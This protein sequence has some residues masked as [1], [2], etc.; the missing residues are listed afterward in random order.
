MHAGEFAVEV[1]LVRR[2]ISSQFPEWAS[3]PLERVASGGT[4]NA[5]F[6]LGA[7]LCVRLPR[8]VSAV[9]QVEKELEWL[10]RLAPALPLEIPQPL[11]QGVPEE[12]YPWAW[13]VY[14]WL[15]GEEV[16]PDAVV[17]AAS[18][19]ASFLAALQRFDTTGGP[20]GRSRGIPLN[21]R[22]ASFRAALA[23]LGDEVDRRALFTVWER[24]LQAPEWEQEPRWLH[25]DLW[26]ANM[27]MRE[28]RLSAI[29]DFAALSVGDPATDLMVAWT[30]LVSETRPLLRAQLGVDDATWMRGRGWA[31]SWAVIALP[32]Y[33]ETNPV[34]V[35]AARRTLDQVLLDEVE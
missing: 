16:D 7:E 3:L 15:E 2:L 34:I 13:G 12:G 23:D 4:D 30:L 18:D 35:R 6:R 19:V 25:G 8:I 10:P 21:R 17:D 32:Y 14:R 5:L 31:V 28:R 27:L 1:P 20:P 29:L 11:V 22:D 24:A 33:L 9:G 26:P